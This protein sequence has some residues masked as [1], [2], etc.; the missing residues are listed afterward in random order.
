MKQ[1]LS[2]LCIIISFNAIGQQKS[3]YLNGHVATGFSSRFMTSSIGINLGYKSRIETG[4]FSVINL[5]T[6]AKSD[7]L[8]VGYLGYNIGGGIT[9]YIANRGG[10]VKW[11]NGK[12]YMNVGMSNWYHDN[13]VGY[14]LIGTNWM[15]VKNVKIP[16][17]ALEFLFMGL[18]GLCS[19][20]AD[21][22]NYHPNAILKNYPNLPR[23]WWVPQEAWHNSDWLG[24]VKNI[25][26]A[27]SFGQRLFLLSA[28]ITYGLH[29]NFHNL[30][31]TWK[32]RL[33]EIAERWAVERA[34]H[35]LM[36]K[37]IFKP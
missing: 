21:V 31:H 27:A 30:K 8:G 20:M 1:L 5:T 4:V 6:K 14:A 25:G 2:I 36:Y 26:H 19:G 29:T 33:L 28:G 10:G 12:V 23:T 13:P 11:A 34:A 18:S 24:P 3:V 17:Q 15:K 16:H 7:F 9:P 32:Y 37:V 22:A 35:D